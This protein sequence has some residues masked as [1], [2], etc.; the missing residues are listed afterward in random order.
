MIKFQYSNEQLLDTFVRVQQLSSIVPAEKYG[1]MMLKLSTVADENR[2]KLGSMVLYKYLDSEEVALFFSHDAA[3]RQ[4]VMT[5][6]LA[7][8][9][10]VFWG[11]YEYNVRFKE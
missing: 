5:T 8:D 10:K 6:L 7:E 11:F 3:K 1:D 4:I 2:L 9:A